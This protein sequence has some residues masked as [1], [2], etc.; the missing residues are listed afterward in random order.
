MPSFA[1]FIK[2]RRRELLLT[3]MKV[4]ARIIQD[5]G[6]PLSMQYLNDI[7]NGRRGAPPDY[8]LK[9]MAKVLRVELDLLYFRASRIPPDI[10][11]R[12]VSDARALAAFTAFRDAL[13]PRRKK[14]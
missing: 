8:V 1:E 12:R 14:S 9:Q 10:Q 5:D 11:K 3:Q 13:R 4:A 2:R 6:K 7:E